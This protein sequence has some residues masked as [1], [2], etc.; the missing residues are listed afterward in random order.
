[1]LAG[2]P[3]D[4]TL[5]LLGAGAEGDGGAGLLLL[6]LLGAGAGGDGTIGAGALAPPLA[7]GSLLPLLLSLLL[8]LPSS[9]RPS[10]FRNRLVMDSSSISVDL[11]AVAAA[12]LLPLLLSAPAPAPPRFWSAVVCARKLDLLAGPSRVYCLMDRL[13]LKN[14]PAASSTTAASAV[15]GSLARELGAMLTK[16]LLFDE[17]HTAVGATK[18]RRRLKLSRQNAQGGTHL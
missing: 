8:L 3:V 11:A 14:R 18:N 5:L 9:S 1:M 7:P 6:L 15:F 17:F 10:A 12:L 2:E 16:G 13:S 4:G